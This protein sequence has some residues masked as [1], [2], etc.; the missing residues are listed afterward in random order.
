MKIETN[1]SFFKSLKDIYSI[2]NKYY[3]VRAWFKYHF[4]KDFFKLLKAVLKS[5]PWDYAYLYELE[6]AK[7]AEMIE[8]H[9]K[10]QHFVGWE[11]VVRDMEICYN[12]ID[13]FL[14]K[15][16]LFNYDGKMKFIPIKGSDNLEMDGSDLKYHCNIYVNTKNIDR[17]IG[18]RHEDIKK[19]W[20]EHPHELY[21]LKA[22]TLYHKIRC[23]H[24]SEWWD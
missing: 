15:K 23:E 20:L 8:Y 10:R 24:D 21:I 13:I 9:R 18:N 7:I 11:E 6:Q 2:K 4:N 22:K 14:E 17:F 12:L 19:Y 3:H 5:Y 16:P 1:Q